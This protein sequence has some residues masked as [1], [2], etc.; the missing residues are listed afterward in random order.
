[1]KNGFNFSTTDEFNSEIAKG[2]LEENEIDCVLVNKKD[3]F[4]HFGDIE[5]YVKRDKIIKANYILKDLKN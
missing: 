2:L 4:Y 3:S 5:I 1:M